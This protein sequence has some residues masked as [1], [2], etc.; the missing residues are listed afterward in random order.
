MI[1]D[2]IVAERF[3]IETDADADERYMGG[4]NTGSR[5]TTRRIVDA[6]ARAMTR[7]L[8]PDITSGDADVVAVC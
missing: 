1:A 3:W 8:P 6:K 5:A 4:R 2:G 7:H